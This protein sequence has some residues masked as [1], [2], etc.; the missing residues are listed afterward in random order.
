[1]WAIAAAVARTHSFV[2]S[3]FNPLKILNRAP[4]GLE[5]F[6]MVGESI[7]DSPHE[8]GQAIAK[9]LFRICL[10]M[11][12]DFMKEN[13]GKVGVNYP[14][15][16]GSGI[17]QE[18]I[19]CAQ[20]LCSVDLDAMTEIDRRAFFINVYNALTIHAIANCKEDVA[21]VL[22]IPL[23]WSSH[24]Y[25]IGEH[26]YSLDDMEHGILRGNKAHPTTKK[27]AFRSRDSRIK[28]IVPLDPRIH[29]A[30]VCGAKSCPALRVYDADNLERGLT[31]AAENF[32][33]QEVQIVENGEQVI[34]S[35]IF[36]WYGLDFGATPVKML[37]KIAHYVTKVDPLLSNGLDTVCTKML[38]SN[39]NFLK[40]K[41]YDWSLNK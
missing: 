29:F 15:L 34:L 17:F 30:L 32:C 41:E 26:I 38:H 16:R 4:T 18:F 7:I 11:E 37:Q 20:E 24:A 8:T 39:R 2:M 35:K 9:K 36:M 5:A 14:A 12:A 40:Y 28:F 23:F 22:N 13:N 19:K 25:Q 6:P 1:M 10:I 21:S 3:Y 31:M 33:R 27:N